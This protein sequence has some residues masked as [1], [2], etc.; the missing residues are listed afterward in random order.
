MESSDR[1]KM[2]LVFESA[3]DKKIPSCNVGIARG[4]FWSGSYT[5][6]VQYTA[7]SGKLLPKAA[8]SRRRAGII[9]SECAQIPEHL[10]QEGQFAAAGWCFSGVHINDFA[11]LQCIL[12]KGLY[13]V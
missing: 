11:V 13:L 7:L 8:S 5:S 9:W 1:I 6:R 12:P 3:P 10:F 4:F 2:L